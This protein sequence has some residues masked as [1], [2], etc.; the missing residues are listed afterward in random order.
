MEA[1]ATAAAEPAHKTNPRDAAWVATTYF[2]QGLPW[3]FLHQMG[4][5]YLT[6]IRA[7]LEQVGYTSWL[8]LAVWLKFILSPPVDSYSTKR[9]WMVVMQF[10][11]GGGMLVIAAISERRNLPL[12]WT[13]MAALSLMHSI[14]DVAS[15]GFYL[16]GLSQKEQALY[17]GIQ[18]GAFRAA[19]L[20][21]T[22]VLVYLAG[23]TDWR[24]G[25]GAAGVL[26][27]LIALTNA[28]FLPH[29]VESVRERA[30]AGAGAAIG[31][32]IWESNVF[33]S[34]RTFFSQPQVAL[35]LGFMFAFRLGFIMMFAMGKPL[36]RDL[37]VGT[38]ARGILNGVGTGFF[39]ASTLLAGG[40]IA[41]IGMRR[42]LIPMIYFQNF[43]I[44]LY[45]LMAALKPGIAGISVI[46]IVEQIAS[47]VGQS[48]NTVF[49]MQR[50]KR[51]FSASHFAFA[52]A[53]VALAS[54]AAGAFSGHIAKHVGYVW[55]FAIAF[56]IS[57]PS[58]IMVHFV[59][60]DPIEKPA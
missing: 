9:R 7:P 41:R 10:V 5:E 34:Y 44:T 59:P 21:G 45:V 26:M 4:T 33:R 27:I 8:H 19:M 20:V 32:R 52:T 40:L 16:I 38:A 13:L 35:V 23:K 58:L 49:L 14:H 22:G 2:G 56:L 6:A 54:V 1:E 28:L 3:S 57:V 30:G 31:K 24:Y 53:V 60:R 55:Y 50:T 51:A 15:D 12:W 47:G 29:P 36:L 39:I 11:V 46:F 18:V 25:F 37:G 43:A 48:A 17:V 42:A